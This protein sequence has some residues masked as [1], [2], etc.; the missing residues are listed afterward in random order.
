M[1]SL[2]SHCLFSCLFVVLQSAVQ[3][4]LIQI[5]RKQRKTGTHRHIFS[6]SQTE[7]LASVLLLVS[8]HSPWLVGSCV[9][10]SCRP[11]SSIV[12]RSLVYY[13]FYY[14]PR[15]SD[16]LVGRRRLAGIYI[17]RTYIH[18]YT[19]IQHTSES[20]TLPP[21]VLY[22][23]TAQPRG[24]TESRKGLLLSIRELSLSLA[25]CSLFF[26]LRLHPPFNH[27]GQQAQPSTA[28]ISS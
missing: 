24:L 3:F 14:F 2:P 21:P 18:T 17:I 7:L 23:R 27:G 9:S 26:Y 1:L 12:L 20:Y 28:P 5:P 19:Y 10:H 15:L 16:S 11:G 25:S 22:L 6:S 4:L 8:C 13:Y